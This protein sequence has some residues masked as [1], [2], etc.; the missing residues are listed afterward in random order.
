MP[1]PA[2]HF[3]K[4]HPDSCSYPFPAAQSTV[5]AAVIPHM[6]SSLSAVI[7]KGGVLLI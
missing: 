3:Q 7:P 5:R 1:F 4:N 2:F 6:P